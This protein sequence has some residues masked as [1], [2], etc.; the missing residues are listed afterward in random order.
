MVLTRIAAIRPSSPNASSAWVT[1]SRGVGEKR[2]AAV[3]DPF[4]RPAD[5][6]RRP[7]AHHFFRVDEDFRA[8]AAADI[9][10]DH[11]QLVLRRHADKSRDD[12]PRHVRI[13][14]GVPQGEA[15]A[16]TI[17][18]ADRGARLHGVRHQAVVDEVEPGHVL[19]RFERRLDG[20][21]VA[22]MPLID[23]VVWRDL[24]DLRRVRELRLGG[25]GH[26]RQHLKVD[27]DFFAGVARLRGGF[28]DRHGDRVA[29]EACF[30]AGDRGMRRHLH[31][32]AVLG[33]DH[34][35][36]DEIADLV[37]GKLRAG[38]HR[39]LPWHG[40]GGSGVD[41]LD[42]GMGMGRAQEMDSGLA[43]AVDVVGVSALAG[44]E[45]EVLLAPNCRADAGRADLC[46]AH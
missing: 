9:G 5:F 8:E 39:E 15:V 2:L 1:W 32:R 24:V 26:H 30:V 21:A 4:D 19:R 36:A 14:G 35:A 33:M 40:A 43:G 13:L 11:P 29:G 12:Q 44:E 18:F 23:G 22:E 42:P 34:P 38:E 6:L 7:Q 10:R 37:G 16:A 25:I 46:R 28:G 17:V 3:G 45:A 27:R 31:R 20:F 41:P